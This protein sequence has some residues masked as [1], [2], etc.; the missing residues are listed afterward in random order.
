MLTHSSRRPGNRWRSTAA[1]VVP[2][3]LTVGLLTAQGTAPAQAEDAIDGARTA[4][5]TL[6]P[7]VGNGGYDA[8]NYDLDLD[9]DTSW[10]SGPTSTSSLKATSTMTATTTGAPL[11]SFSMDF[12]GLTID[13]VRVDGKAA[14]W[15]RDVDA[16]AIKYKL[17]IT[18]AKAVSGT[19]TVAVKYHG[20]PVTH[21][22]ADDSW[23]GWVNT[24]DGVIFM[25]QPIGSMAGYPNNNTPGDK[26]TYDV[27]IQV[28]TTI[29][30]AT[31]TGPAAAVS[32]GELESRIVSEDGERTTWTW[33]QSKPQA[34]ELTLINIGKFDV[35]ESTITLDDGRTL[36][37]WSFIDSAQSSTNKTTF[38]A[39]V[40][41]LGPIIDRLEKIYGAYPGNS[42]GVVVDTV[43]DGINY[44]LETQDRSF[45]PSVRSLNGGTLIHELVHQWYGN[46]VSPKTWQD[47]WIN[48]GMASWGPS[49]HDDVLAAE[50]PDAAAVESEFFDAWNDVA[51]DREEWAIAPARMTDSATLYEFQTY[52]RG[53]QFWEALRT[54][55]G[56]TAF[57]DVVKGW[58]TTY[59]GTSAG[60]EE[61][62]ALAERESGHDLD[63]FFQ[64]WIF[65]TGKPA[66]PEKVD[67]V[68]KAE[69]S[70]GAVEP[71]DT[72][73]YTLTAANTGKVPLA[74]TVVEVDLSD[75][76]DDA[77]LDDGGLPDGLALGGTTLV[78]TVPATAVGGTATT[79]FSVVV[80][81]DASAATLDAKASVATLGG[82]CA[83][84]SV[85]H[86][87]GAQ[88]IPQ[89]AAPVVVGTPAVG[90]PLTARTPGW[91]SG[92]RF[93]YQWSVGGTKIAGATRPTFTPRASDV[94]RRV[95]V[96]VTGSRPPYALTTQTS[97]P[98]GPVAKGTLSGRVAVVGTR[99]V[100]RT[101]R[102]D[103]SGFGAGVT[104]RYAW[105]VGGKKVGS[106]SRLKLTTSMAGRS[107]KV[108]VTV[109]KAG[110]ATTSVTSRA[111]RISKKK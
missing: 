78:W 2:V 82:T 36:P 27:S 86:T 41:Q 18:P 69:P 42:T 91:T 35:D 106:R 55:I 99:K 16:D 83:S 10:T 103:T 23:E 46:N 19:F 50:T 84:C 104:K 96:A 93:T 56:D 79:T 85:S 30:S 72:V 49:Y 43:P 26:A 59:G 48:E 80:D 100:G 44:A 34:S 33:T 8:L 4:G 68:L 37:Q 111:K 47:I 3:L 24:S 81:A 65:E 5:D 7:N 51:S 58:Q 64:D 25:G 22:D 77:G 40:A 97:A 45:F 9:V 108:K 28:P 14:T 20:A 87:V 13:S 17:V 101:V 53:A 92:T 71:G 31:G 63:A 70:T 39:R 52:D 89:S 105:Y 109:R 62:Q 21:V 15:S 11:K 66:W 1:R 67:L 73:A 90:R 94:G 29:T 12:E 76:L 107:V 102:A 32:N 75:V 54:A 60:A 61:L 74:T 95:T 38:T 6:F 88:P 57:F 98:T 110:Y